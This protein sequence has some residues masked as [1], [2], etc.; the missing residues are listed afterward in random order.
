MGKFISRHMA[1]VLILSAMGS[2]SP[3][4]AGE[5]GRLVWINTEQIRLHLDGGDDLRV[6]VDRVGG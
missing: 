2:V 1:A 6:R 4:S 3:A 5:G